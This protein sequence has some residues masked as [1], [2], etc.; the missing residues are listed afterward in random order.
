MTRIEGHK[1]ND[2]RFEDEGEE[3]YRAVSGV[4]K[5]IPSL[6]QSEA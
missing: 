1:K 5:A 2:F 4:P 3:L 6:T